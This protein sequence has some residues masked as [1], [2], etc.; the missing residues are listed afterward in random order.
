MKFL[1][2]A[3]FVCNAMP[4][5]SQL[6]PVK[7]L[8]PKQPINIGVEN[9]KNIA[10]NNISSNIYYAITS[11]HSGLLLQ[12][13]GND[14]LSNADLYQDIDKVI[15]PNGKVKFIYLGGNEYKIVL[16]H[17]GKYLQG[18]SNPGDAITQ[19]NQSNSPR[20]IFIV[21]QIGNGQYKFYLKYRDR[22]SVV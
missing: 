13:R 4:L 10:P 12:V 19:Q 17:S 5:F 2:A 3:L 15:R 8:T 9:V 20:Q 7:T 11:K 14:T 22:K 21:K 1:L 6:Q 18:G 16:L